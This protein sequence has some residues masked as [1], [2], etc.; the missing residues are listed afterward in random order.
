[1]RLVSSSYH[2][3]AT[4]L[5]RLFSMFN[6]YYPNSPN[7]NVHPK[8]PFCFSLENSI[9]LEVPKILCLICYQLLLLLCSRSYPASA[10]MCECFIL[11][12]AWIPCNDSEVLYMQPLIVCMSE[13]LFVWARLTLDSTFVWLHKSTLPAW[14]INEFAQTNSIHSSSLQDPVAKSPTRCR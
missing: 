5:E 4:W 12:S 13:N 10:Y 1:M 6:S 2:Q 9:K 3:L 8:Y 7:R 11:N 14:A